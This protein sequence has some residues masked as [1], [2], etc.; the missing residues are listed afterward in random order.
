MSNIDLNTCVPGQLVE[1]RN[2]DIVKYI[3]RNRNQDT[4][5]P[6]IVGTFSYTDDGY[7]YSSRKEDEDDVVRILPLV[8]PKQP[9][10]DAHPSVAWWESCPWITDRLPTVDDISQ[11]YIGA[12]IVLVRKNEG[13]TLK[14]YSQVTKNEAWIHLNTWQ[15]LKQTPKEK[16]LALIA[17]HKDS[18]TVGVWVPTP[19]DWIV[20]C[21]GLAE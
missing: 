20:I 12:N 3:G 14:W 8:K 6:H 10:S 21:E 19:D 15:P 13:V 1:R 4:L 11:D 16:A 2:G 17:K 9:K 7:Y 5:Y 18:S